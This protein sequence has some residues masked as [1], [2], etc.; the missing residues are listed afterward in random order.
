[1]EIITGRERR[2]RWGI[3]EKL[4]ILAE[5]TE[6]DAVVRAVAARN[7]ICESLLYAW[8][9][10]QRDGTLRES[11]TPA[12]VPVRVFG[13]PMNPMSSTSQPERTSSST[14][15]QTRSD[16]IEIEMGDGRQVRVGRDVNLAALRRVLT[17][18]RS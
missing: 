6:P 3:E 2:R 5:T 17:A 11:G 10:Q 12:F 14:R 1:M 4:R 13:T 9:R 16:L 18:L 15:S 7:G 8:R